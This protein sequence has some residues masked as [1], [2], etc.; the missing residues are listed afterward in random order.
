MNMGNALFDEEIVE[1]TNFRVL[2]VN[3]DEQEREQYLSGLGGDFDLS[4]SSNVQS[5]WEFLNSAPLPDAIILDVI[6]ESED[7]VKLCNLISETQ[8]LQDVPII[9]VSALNDPAVRS[10]AFE[11]GGADFVSKPPMMTELLARLRRHTSLYRKTKKLESLIFIDPLTHLPNEAKFQQVLRVEWA[12]CARY[13]HHL[14]LLVIRVDNLE[15]IRELDGNDKY[16]ATIAAVAN[17]LTSAGN[18]PGD[19]VA[20][21]NNNK[22]AVLLSDCG[23]EGATLKAKQIMTKFENGELANTGASLYSTVGYAV[24]APAGGGSPEALFRSVD[25]IMLEAQQAGKVYAVKGII[26]VAE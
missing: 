4:F 9:F 20:T 6:I 14:T 22:F 18:R 16:F 2:V 23:H 5:A 7:N 3:D 26:G 1:E 8:F 17:G 10:Q 24:A 13:W 19:L 11:L 12:R 25:N 21:L 15:S